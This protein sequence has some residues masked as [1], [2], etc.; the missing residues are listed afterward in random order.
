MS[1]R[2][3]T[4]FVG[5][6]A[7]GGAERATGLAT[8]GTTCGGGRISPS[9][10]HTCVNG[11]SGSEQAMP[12]R[13]EPGSDAQMTEEQ[14]QQAADRLAADEAAMDREEQR[15]AEQPVTGRDG[16]KYAH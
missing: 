5:P 2:R 14:R 3:R 9:G 6:T 11:E 13:D 1:T 16:P 12:E 7:S 15:T 4:P 10:P 8:A